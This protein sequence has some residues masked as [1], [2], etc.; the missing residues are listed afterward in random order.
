MQNGQENLG[1]YDLKL[2]TMLCAMKSYW[3]IGFI[4][5]ELESG[6]SEAVCIYSIRGL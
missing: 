2:F 1:V 6:A 5:M 3:A 4:S